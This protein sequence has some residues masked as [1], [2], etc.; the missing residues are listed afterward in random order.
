VY[1]GTP[2]GISIGS[3]VFA[4][5]ISMTNRQTHRPRIAVGGGRIYATGMSAMR[6][7]LMSEITIQS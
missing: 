5:H 6:P 7:K 4:Q 1:P 2:N 3:A